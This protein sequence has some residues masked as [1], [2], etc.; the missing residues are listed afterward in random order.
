MHRQSLDSGLPQNQ[1]QINTWIQHLKQRADNNPTPLVPPI[2]ALL[3]LVKQDKQLLLLSKQMFCPPQQTQQ[4]QL[5]TLVLQS[6][7]EFIVLLNAVMTQAP[8]YIRSN[9][10]TAEAFN[11]S[12]FIG[13]PINAL[14][15]AAIT[16]TASRHFFANQLVC[17]QFK[18]IL[19]YWSVYLTSEASRNV[20]VQDCLNQKPQILAWLN[21]IVQKQIIDI[22]C[23]ASFDPALKAFP[24]EHY[25]ECDPNDEFYGF[26]SWDDF[27]TRKFTSSIRPIAAGEDI[28][29]NPCESAPLQVVE[30]VELNAKFWL[31]GHPYSLQNMMN[32]DPLAEQFVGGTVY[33]AYLNALSYHRWHSPVS[34]TIKKID[35]V[36]GSYDYAPSSSLPFLTAVATRAIIFIESDNPYIGLMCF[37]AVGIA[38]VSSCEVTVTQGQHVD[39][40]QQLG[41]FHCG[42]STHCLIFGP[43]VNLSFDFHRTEP[44]LN[45]TNIPVCSCIAVVN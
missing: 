25:F 35:I 7:D 17:Q 20:L 33:Q 8:A 2:K 44:G 36:N 32:F 28:I 43:H 23:Q 16:S 11:P 10:L 31:K 14:L 37:I 34:G 13:L 42:G 3:E 45:A 9:N 6:F 22:A 29:A 12:G 21:P 41:M 18:K 26:K 40:G 30:N 39:K 27:F 24:F 4:L 5:S 38:E 15:T 1:H 19:A